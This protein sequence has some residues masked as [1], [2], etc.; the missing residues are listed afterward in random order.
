MA[1]YI[2]INWI[3]RW[4]ERE[5][6][7]FTTFCISQIATDA[8]RP[9]GICGC[10]QTDRYALYMWRKLFLFGLLME[11]DLD[12]EI[13]LQIK[14]LIWWLLFTG[15]YPN[16]GQHSVAAHVPMLI[17]HTSHV[18]W[19]IK[20]TPMS[21]WMIAADLL[22]DRHTSKNMFLLFAGAHYFEKVRFCAPQWLHSS[23]PKKKITYR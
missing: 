9:S 21:I 3:E 2:H 20:H 5:R 7:A 11:I 22:H 23:E 1:M 8:L 4:V 6:M 12:L 15:L 16:N 19:F 13:H 18:H 14:W 17:W 10:R